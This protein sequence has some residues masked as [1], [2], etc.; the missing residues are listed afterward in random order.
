MILTK[1]LTLSILIIREKNCAL[2]LTEFLF[3]AQTFIN[4]CCSPREAQQNKNNNAIQEIFSFSNPSI[5]Q[6][7]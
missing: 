1:P 7:S 3:I 5:V 4:C 6:F 2:K